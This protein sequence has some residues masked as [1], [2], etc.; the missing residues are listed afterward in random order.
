MKK[1]TMIMLILGLIFICLG[2]CIHLVS[3]QESPATDPTALPT[4]PS[5]LP[6]E[7]TQAPTAPTTPPTEP[8][9][10]TPTEPVDTTP[11]EPGQREIP[12]DVPETEPAPSYD[13]YF[14]ET[15]I[16]IEQDDRGET[17]NYANNDLRDSIYAYRLTYEA[18]HL[19]VER[20]KYYENERL[21]EVAE[22]PDLQIMVYDERWIY[23]IEGGT[24]L[25]RM[26]YFG[27]NRQLLFRDES[28]LISQLQNRI[29]VADEKVAF[30][31]AGNAEGGASIYR[32]YLPEMKLDVMYHYG[33][34]EL[35]AF[36]FT[37]PYSREELSGQTE[38]EARY[39]ISFGRAYSNH[40]VL[41]GSSNPVFFKMLKEKA[42]DPQWY[43][44]HFG[45]TEIE[46]A[47]CIGSVE[48]E[49]Q[50]WHRIDYYYN[51]LTDTY[52]TVETGVFN[53]MQI[54]YPWWEKQ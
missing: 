50:C 42:A 12:W 53:E 20:Y 35:E 37:A 39:Q 23:A 13:D 6:T 21:W 33:K 49:Y 32:L 15:V 30:F 16:Y 18:P 48:S 27:E 14:A 51:A 28:G 29:I 54:F 19:Y 36:Y 7:P 26:D 25:F 43:E 22:I 2:V 34:E 8:A 46:F 52:R 9:D 41:W 11:T 31:M 38:V 3:L 44:V 4:D 24:D 5:T 10:T 17:Y 1:M 45:N 40:E 47:M